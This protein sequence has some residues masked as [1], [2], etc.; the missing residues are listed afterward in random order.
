MGK[1]YIC[2][3]CK[4][5]VD[6]QEDLAVIVRLNKEYYKGITVHK[7][8]CDTVL[9]EYVHKKLGGSAVTNVDLWQFQTDAELDDYLKTGERSWMAFK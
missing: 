4:K 6:R 2:E 3:V 5:P 9:C 8:V 7:G 1:E